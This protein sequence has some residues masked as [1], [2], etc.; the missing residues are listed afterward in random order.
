VLTLARLCVVVATV[1]DVAASGVTE[2]P[3]DVL[4]LLDVEVFLV[5]Q[6]PAAR[7]VLALTAQTGCAAATTP[8][9]DHG[10][11]V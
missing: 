7:V 6:H 11:R 1:S 3:G 10:R 8:Y 4:L 2:T 9:G 5:V